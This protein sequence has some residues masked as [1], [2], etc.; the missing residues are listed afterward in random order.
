MI[1]SEKGSPGEIY[2]IGDNEFHTIKDTVETICDLMRASK[3]Y[4][5]IE[6]D[7]IEIPFQYMSAEKLKKL[8]WKK[9]YTFK[10]GLNK[11]IEWYKKN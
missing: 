6:K 8:G 11:T 3:K 9:K 7:F 5:I 2:N 4:D 1:L 10:N